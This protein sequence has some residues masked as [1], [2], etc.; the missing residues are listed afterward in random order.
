[1]LALVAPTASAYARQVQAVDGDWVGHISF[2]GTTAWTDQRARGGFEFTSAGGE[3]EGTFQWAGGNTQIGGVVRGPDTMPLFVLTSGV[4]NG[5]NIPVA[6]GGGEILFTVAT[7]ERLEGTGVNIGVERMGADAWIRRCGR[8]HRRRL[9][10]PSGRAG[11]APWA[12]APA[13]F[14]FGHFASFTSMT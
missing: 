4:S 6:D 13:A 1:M 12:F 11:N 14:T 2:R 10:F 9:S 7:C 8:R 5:V 3:V